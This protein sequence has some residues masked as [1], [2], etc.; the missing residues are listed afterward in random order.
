MQ[1]ISCFVRPLASCVVTLVLTVSATA[2]RADDP[3]TFAD[4]TDADVRDA[5]PRFAFLLNPLAMAVG[6]FGGE[7]DF[8][9]G[10]YAA[11]AIEGDL[12]RRGDMT[13]EAL[14]AGLA[15][16]PMGSALEG[17]FLEPRL[18]YARPSSEAMTKADW[19]VDVVG[20]GGTAGWQWTWDYGFSVR[21]G[22]GA[23]YFLGGP[24]SGP[25]S[26]PL[27]LGPQVVLDGSLGWAF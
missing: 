9:L 25:S 5:D 2:A 8:V 19:S 10:R 17:F 23:M 13:G 1:H 3:P 14:G 7:A 20:L 16:Y 22:G 21:L 6:V 27:A 18:A 4:R 11:L 24:R 26:E 12:Y 15:F